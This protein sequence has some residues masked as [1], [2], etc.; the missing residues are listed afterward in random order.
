MK[1][2]R[3]STF[4]FFCCLILGIHI[5]SPLD[6]A[7]QVTVL[8]GSYRPSSLVPQSSQEAINWSPLTSAL[9]P[10]VEG[11]SAY[12]DGKIYVFG[13][14]Q[15]QDIVPTDKNEVYDIATDTWST[16]EPLPHPVT[17]VGSAEVDGKVWLAGGFALLDYTQIVDHVWIYDPVTDSWTA[18]PSLPAKRSAG[19]MVRLGRKLHYFS[20]LINRN[21]NTG[22]HYVL[23]LDEPGGPKT[24]T[25]AAPMPA[26]RDHLS[27]VSL[28]GKIYAIGGQFGHDLDPQDTDL[29]H[30]YDPATDSWTELAGLPFIRSHY[31]PGTVAVDGKILIA[32]GR[33]GTQNCTDDITVYDPKTDQWNLLYDMPY[34]A[35]APSAKVIG[36]ELFLS[37]GGKVSVLFPTTDNYKRPF[38]RSPSDTLGFW[39]KEVSA[40]LEGSN[41]QKVESVL[42]T[43]TGEANYSIDTGSLPSW[44]KSVTPTNGTADIPGAEID[45][46]LDATGLQPG[47]YTHSIT[48]TAS[49]YDNAQLLVSLHVA[50]N[51]MEQQIEAGWNLVGLPITPSNPNYASVYGSVDPD[52]AP[53]SYEGKYTASTN[54]APG[55][56]YWLY[57]NQAGTQN[58]NGTAKTSISYALLK[59]WNLISGPACIFPLS[60]ATGDTGIW[61]D[62]KAYGYAQSNAYSATTHLIPGKGY[63]IETSAAGNVTMDCSGL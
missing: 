40:T 15:T 58:L 11:H 37:H 50:G 12:I 29:V 13:G 9:E 57:T 5:S 49:G 34:C 7:A 3:L 26:P 33:T 56:G 38:D 59:G 35:L 48:A 30:M 51:L 16:F 39:P 22:D 4:F 47:V 52:F 8:E 54:L 21:D 63:W 19:A 55:A 62:G 43:Y 14:F 53:Y 25:T 60:E 42:W 31:E 44:I 17:H 46:V 45:L 2:G 41:S 18:G 23:D 1:A 10:R 6:I 36:D 61:T 24:W 20:G 32:G 27:G 28:G